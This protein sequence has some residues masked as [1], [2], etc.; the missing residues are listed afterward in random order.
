MTPAL[1]TARG[2]TLATATATICAV[3]LAITAAWWMA[4][5]ILYVAAFL[6]WCA[7]RDYARHRRIHLQALGRALTALGSSTAC[8]HLAE[9]SDGQAHNPSCVRRSFSDLYA[10]CC[11]EAFVSRGV[12]HES[13]CQSRTTKS[14]A[15]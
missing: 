5:T 3:Y 4:A 2:L 7:S 1:R 9:H 14:S 12:Q 6:A 8:C 11:V 15:A 13:A 10:T